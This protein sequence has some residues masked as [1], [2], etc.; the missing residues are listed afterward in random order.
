MARHFS[1]GAPGGSREVGRNDLSG[2]PGCIL[3]GVD[4]NTAQRLAEALEEAASPRRRNPDSGLSANQVQA[5]QTSLYSDPTSPF[6]RAQ[7][8]KREYLARK[9]GRRARP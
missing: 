4:D 3:E 1:L 8:R 7:E 5:V 6:R 9:D 2:T